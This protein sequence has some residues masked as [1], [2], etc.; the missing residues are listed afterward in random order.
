MVKG[1]GLG[2]LAIL[3]DGDKLLSTKDCFGLPLK[4]VL[5]R[6]RWSTGRLVSDLTLAS[7]EKFLPTPFASGV[8]GSGI[9]NCYFLKYSLTALNYRI[10]EAICMRLLLKSSV[11]EGSWL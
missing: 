1:Y 8:S 11:I 4:L 10:C 3:L 6:F 2:I 7:P 5:K 9:S